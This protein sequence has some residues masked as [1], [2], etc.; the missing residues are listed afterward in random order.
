MT[1]KKDYTLEE[2]R[3][4]TRAWIKANPEKMN[5]HGAKRRAA[6]LQ[7]TVAW[8]DQDAIKDFYTDCEEFNLAAATAG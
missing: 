3:E 5:A 1:K 6:K 2:R 4:S 8:A 7:R